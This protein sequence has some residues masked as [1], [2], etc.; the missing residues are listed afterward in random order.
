[1]GFAGNVI[2]QLIPRNALTKNKQT[3]PH[4]HVCIAQNMKITFLIQKPGNSWSPLQH[5]FVSCFLIQKPA[6]GM[7]PFFQ[8]FLRM[9]AAW[10]GTWSEGICKVNPPSCACDR[11]WRVE[12]RVWQQQPRCQH[13]T[14]WIALPTTTRLHLHTLAHNPNTKR[15]HLQR[16]WVTWL[17]LVCV[18]IY[19]ES[20]EV[21]YVPAAAVYGTY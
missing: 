4:H 17:D 8:E 7:S 19:R 1:M 10:R 3:S 6:T 11:P 14:V 21:L 5:F 16:I 20:R 9:S 12:S 2:P 18:Y 15:E 13:R